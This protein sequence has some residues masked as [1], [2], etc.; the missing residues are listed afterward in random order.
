M[1][2]KVFVETIVKFDI[3]GNM[4]P[5]SITWENGHI[6]EIDKI[7]DVRRAASLKAGGMGWRYACVIEKK[8]TYLF[9]DLCDKKW[10]VDGK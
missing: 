8:E 7:T 10:F 4:M 2:R 9:Y 3:E 6:Y 1:S 5:L